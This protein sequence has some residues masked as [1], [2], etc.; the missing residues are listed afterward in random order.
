MVKLIVG[1]IV[2]LFL[3]TSTTLS[4]A[5]P[6]GPDS[7]S[8]WPVAKDGG[9]MCTD[10]FHQQNMTEKAFRLGAAMPGTASSSRVSTAH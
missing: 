2:G 6:D 10:Q 9:R 7:L 3:S 1:L 4:G 5:G 8:G